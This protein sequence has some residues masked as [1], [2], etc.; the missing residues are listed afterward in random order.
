MVAPLLG[1]AWE[2]LQ[3]Q[4]QNGDCTFPFKEHS[5]TQTFRQVTKELG[6]EDLHT[7]TCAGKVQA[8]YLKQ[9]LA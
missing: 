7:T 4:P 8:D 5:L 6:V 1:Q 9:D 3:G 2:I